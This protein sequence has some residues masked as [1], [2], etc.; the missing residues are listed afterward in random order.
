MRLVYI[1]FGNH[2]LGL[3][4][5][6]KDFERVLIDSLIMIHLIIESNCK[7]SRILNSLVFSIFFLCLVIILYNDVKI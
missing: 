2:T 3:N 6:P 5:L 7:T 1:G 4:D